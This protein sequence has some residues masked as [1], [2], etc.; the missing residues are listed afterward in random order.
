MES[1]SPAPEG[2]GERVGRAMW[3]PHRRRTQ[4]SRLLNIGTALVLAAAA[5]VYGLE[6]SPLVL[7]GFVVVMAIATHVILRKVLADADSEV[8]MLG[9][10][11]EDAQAEAMSKAQF[12]A[13]MSH[14]IR[15]PMNGILG[16]A[17][18]LVESDLDPEQQQ[19]A[20]TVQA[21]AD[22]L[23]AVLND[24][25]DFSKIE[26]GKLE[27]ET[28]D[29]DLW[30][31]VDECAGLM[32]KTADEKGVELLTYVD[33]R[34]H[35][36]HRGDSARLRQVLMNFLSNAVKFTIEGEVVVGVDLLE[37]AKSGERL[38]FWV[39]DTGVGIAREAI[40]RL[41]KPFMQAD[42]ST[43]RRFGGTGL[44]LVICRR[45]VEL[46]D[47]TLDV[48]S[49]VGRGSTFSFVVE[50]PIGDGRHARKRSE[51]VD[52]AGHSVLIVDDNETNRN[53]MVMQLA[54]TRIGID[55][56]GNAISAI[57]MMRNAARTG[58]PFSMAILDMAMP[59]IDGMQ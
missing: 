11:V 3:S 42:T 44:G 51:E 40:P 2:A 21:S 56:A 14:E 50:L 58:R 5:V 47:G 16:M 22:A 59:G 7:V 18:L 13:N 48:E 38:R 26:A 35:R 1:I 28:V 52:L 6:W 8:A 33:P 30:Q 10:A 39:R 12:L 20:A 23:L 49:E 29:F 54:P 32:H 24:I 15:T 53:L 34:I 43:T 4:L 55:V 17:E 41:F 45:L 9:H 25:L 27:L 37:G 31:L 57:E 46:M 19:M 36:C